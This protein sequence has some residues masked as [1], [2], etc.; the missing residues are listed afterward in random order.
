MNYPEPCLH[1]VKDL[2]S[3]LINESIFSLSCPWL[4]S[5]RNLSMDS[6]S[7]PYLFIQ[8]RGKLK[9]HC[10]AG[11]TITDW[12]RSNSFNNPSFTWSHCLLGPS[13]LL[14]I[15]YP[16]YSLCKLRKTAR[17][18]NSSFRTWLLSLLVSLFHSSLPISSLTVNSFTWFPSVFVFAP[19]P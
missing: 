17:R 11:R 8:T 19:E 10:L 2:D 7:F 12:T 13:P 9:F 1:S 15:I 4:N 3:F 14:L 18:M 16:I 5:G 6:F